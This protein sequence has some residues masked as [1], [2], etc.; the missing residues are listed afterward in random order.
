MAQ[1]LIKITNYCF[2]ENRDIIKCPFL[3]WLNSRRSYTP[4]VVPGAHGA[5]Q[6]PDV[7]LH[8]CHALM[9]PAD[10]PESRPI[11]S[12]VLASATL[13]A[14]PSALCFIACNEAVPDIQGSANSL[15]AYIVPCV[16]IT[17]FVHPRNGLRHRRNTR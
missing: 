16:R 15:V 17:D 11:G 13:T 3:T 2:P 14:S 8:A 6:V 10:P 1:V 5:S 7:S 4:S 9:T 12:F